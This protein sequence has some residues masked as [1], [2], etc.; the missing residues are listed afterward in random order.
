V[1]FRQ[2][3]R[4]SDSSCL[5]LD[6]A[7]GKSRAKKASAS[8]SAIKIKIASVTPMIGGAMTNFN[9]G[10]LGLTFTHKERLTTC[11]LRK[12]A[13]VTSMLRPPVLWRFCGTRLFIFGKVP[14]PKSA[15]PGALRYHSTTKLGCATLGRIQ[16]HLHSFRALLYD[17]ARWIYKND[18]HKKPFRAMPCWLIRGILAVGTRSRQVFALAPPDQ[19]LPGLHSE[20][21]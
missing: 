17:Q 16:A 6:R 9:R 2:G 20:A 11:P 13:L 3:Y 10:C 14:S 21:W 15:W 5:G 8:I 4:L 1:L 7:Q 12:C 18:P 19:L